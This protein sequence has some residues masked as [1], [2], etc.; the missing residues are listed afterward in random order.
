MLTK[1]YAVLGSIITTSS[2][3]TNLATFRS[4]VV[5]TTLFF[6]SSSFSVA[7]LIYWPSSAVASTKATRYFPS[8]R[9][10]VQQ[11][12]F[13]RGLDKSKLRIRNVTDVSS[14]PRHVDEGSTS[15]WH[16]LLMLQFIV[17]GA[18]LLAFLARVALLWLWLATLRLL[19]HLPRVLPCLLRVK[20]RA[21]ETK[22]SIK[23]FIK[24]GEREWHPDITC[25]YIR[26]FQ[27]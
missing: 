23:Y 3:A 18:L 11:T 20:K 25:Y 7:K 19:T 6:E 24:R 26:H 22:N 15:M 8:K 17:L 21:R 2:H 5:V 1:A 13:C 9:S 12:F 16:H 4:S 14:T 27:I 10:E